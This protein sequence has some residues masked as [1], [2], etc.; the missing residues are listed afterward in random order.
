MAFTVV[1]NNGIDTFSGTQ[2]PVI[3]FGST[4]TSGNVLVAA[5]ITNTAATFADPAGGFTRITDQPSGT[6]YDSGLYYRLVQPGDTANYTLTTIFSANEAGSILAVEMSGNHATTPIGTTQGVDWETDDDVSAVS[7]HDIP[8]W[9]PPENNCA[10]LHF[11]MGETTG[12]T[13]GSSS[14]TELIDNQGAAH[15]WFLQW[16]EQTTATAVGP[17]ITTTGTTFRGR[18]YGVTIRPAAVAAAQSLIWQPPTTST[19]YIR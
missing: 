10:V 9:T 4:P 15:Y 2:S 19:V 1:Q 17:T 14:L 16:Q 18:Q 6:A 7:S 12:V 5:I 3:S 11:L 8:A 13:G